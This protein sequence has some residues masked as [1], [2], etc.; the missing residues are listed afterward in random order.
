MYLKESEALIEMDNKVPV[1]YIIHP[2]FR[3]F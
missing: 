3:R 2:K 1:K